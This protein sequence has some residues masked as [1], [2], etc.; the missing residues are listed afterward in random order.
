LYEVDPIQLPERVYCG[1]YGNAAIGKIE[2][3][4]RRKGFRAVF[5]DCSSAWAPK[6]RR[7]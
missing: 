1:F 6:P 2:R 7:T 5:P 4:Q 3:A